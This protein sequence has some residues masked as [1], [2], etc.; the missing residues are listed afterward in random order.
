MGWPY[1][2]VFRKYK[3][4]CTTF[5][6]TGTYLGDSVQY[7]LDLG[8]ERI[9]SV[10]IE[11]RFYDHCMQRFQPLN[12][13]E[14]VKLFLGSSENNIENLVNDWIIGRTMFWLDAHTHNSPYKLEIETITK[15]K[16]NDHVIIVDDVDN[17]GIDINWIKNTLSKRN[18][19]YIFDEI[20]V[21]TSKQLIAYLA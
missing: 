2:E 8:F 7:A 1:K 3:S 16:R 19:L 12:V 9:I 15:H 18:P 11:E 10:E 14:K 6:E 13:W 17:Y 20:Q 21:T 4:D 5:F